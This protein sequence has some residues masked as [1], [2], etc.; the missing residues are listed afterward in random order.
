MPHPRPWIGFEQLVDLLRDHT[1]TVLSGAGVSTES[2]IP[3][4]RGP[5]TREDDRS[6]IQFQVFVEEKRTRRHYWA[7]S[8]VGWPAVDAAPP[9]D[10]HRALA[11]LEAANVVNGIITQNVDRLHQEAGSERVVELHG[12][13]A[14][15]LCL[16]CGAVTSRRTLQKRLSRLNPGW[17]RR[18]AELAP[19]GDADIP[20]AATQ[21]Y[22]IPTCR[23]CGGTLK[24]NVVFFGEDTDADRVTNAWTLLDEADAL[25]VTG[26]SLSVYSGYRFVLGADR[27]NKP[28]GIV[29]L[30]AP[31]GTSRSDVHVEGRTGD[32]LPRLA[33][34]LSPSAQNARPHSASASG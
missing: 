1:V 29:N 26:S 9:N 17:T 32:V 12:A 3:D 4:Y 21:H 31:R 14:E 15:V 20:K 27:A 24:P 28:I 33:D 10:G 22:R 30:G 11:R 5:N 19:D 8:A 7:R 18:A 16:D 23:L 25:L 2:G 13:L 6:P 34:I